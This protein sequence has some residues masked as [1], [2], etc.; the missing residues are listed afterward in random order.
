MSESSWLPALIYICSLSCRHC[1]RLLNVNFQSNAFAVK[2][3]FVYLR[4]LKMAVCNG[5]HLFICHF[6]YERAISPGLPVSAP[7]PLLQQVCTLWRAAIKEPLARAGCLCLCV[8]GFVCALV[9]CM[10]M[11][12]CFCDQLLLSY[13]VIYIFVKYL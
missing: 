5:R 7:I 2:T 1:V 10:Y 13:I 4:V 8:G 12:L 3:Q 6:D 9:A 11:S